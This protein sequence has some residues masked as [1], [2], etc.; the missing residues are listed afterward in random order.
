MTA[1]THMNSQTLSTDTFT[2]RL[3]VFRLWLYDLG[4]FK[5][6]LFGNYLL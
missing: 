2:L 5:A 1:H 6:L 4:F 3:Q